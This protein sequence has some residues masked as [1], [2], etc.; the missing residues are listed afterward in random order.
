[1]LKN[2]FRLFVLA[3]IVG[4]VLSAL[5]VFNL[6]P[7]HADLTPTGNNT[8]DQ[9][10][11][12]EQS[13]P[14][15]LKENKVSRNKSYDE[16]I[17]RAQLL[18]QNN[19]PTLAIAQ[20][21]E[22]YNKDN[23]NS[24]PLIEIGRIY[25]RTNNFPKAEETFR[26]LYSQNPNNDDIKIYLGRSLINQRKISEARPLIDSVST[27]TQL[28]KYY[29]GI[30]AAFF[31]E[32]DKA[33]D[34]LNQSVGL[35]Q[36]NGSEDL[37]KKAKNFLNAYN[38]FKSNVESPD[39]HLKVLLA[40]S[41]NQCGEYQMAIPLLFEVTKAK[42]D[43]RD[44]WI[45]LGFAYL[46]TGKYQDAIEALERAKILDNQKPETLFYLG[47]G[48]YSVNDF[49]K[50][51]ENLSLAKQYGFQPEILVD[52]KLA[53]VYLQLQNYSKSAAAYEQLLG[54][55][56]DD[57]NYFIRPIWIYLEKTKEP[58]KA[59]ALAQKA[60]SLHPNQAMS[61]NLMG[62]TLI[63]NN[64]FDQAE[65][66]LKQAMAIDPNLDATYLN[67][68]ILFEM[69]NQPDK[70]LVF[71]QKAHKL[72]QGDNI[73]LSAADRYN[74]LLAQSNNSTLKANLLNQ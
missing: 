64:Q 35:G 45:L 24:S 17:Q 52:Q 33:K 32:H 1:M 16:M 49:K 14:A 7:F 11:K 22:A 37:T 61:H 30:L 72:G 39:V 5:Y 54:L 29:Q 58:S 38:E 23:S 67:F 70:A 50:A 57:V 31:G 27:P 63:Y 47:L 15:E 20:Y 28:S 40:R 18:E 44:A 59:L 8:T 43:Y 68:G 10:A 25:L 41:F 34:L 73:A 53:E 56:S 2:I 13:L 6:P 66:E 51:E 3:L 4:I 55:N 21:Q 65:Q 12:E 71:Y 19:F 36:N 42:L 48:Y 74:K 46:Q 26:Q 62:W 69:K 60:A 9:L